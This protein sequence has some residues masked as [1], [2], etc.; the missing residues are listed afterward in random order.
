[1]VCTLAAVSTSTTVVRM[2]WCLWCSTSLWGGGGRDVRVGRGRVSGDVGLRGMW[3]S[4]E[5]VMRGM[6][7]SVETVMRGIWGSVETVMRGIWGSVEAVMRGM[8]GSVEAVM[9]GMWG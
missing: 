2:L 3:G 9:R 4:V 7:D 8:C 6:W 5:T 1:M